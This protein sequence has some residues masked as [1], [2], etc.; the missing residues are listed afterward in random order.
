[1]IHLFIGT[2]AQFIKMAP[3]MAEMDR[4][5]LEYNYIDSG[6]HEAFTQSLRE[7]FGIRAPN[8][9]LGKGGLDI[10]TMRSAAVWALRLW[11]G[12][13]F[14]KKWLREEVF[15]SGGICLAHGDTLS[16]LLGLRM[17]KTAGCVVG[18]VEAGLRSRSFFHPFPE[19]IIRMYCMRR[20]ELLFAPSD[21]A[22]RNLIDMRVSGE[23]VHVGGN[24][25]VDALRLVEKIDPSINIPSVP[26]ALAACHR[27]E[28]ITNKKRLGAVVNLLNRVSREMRVLFVTH[29]P[30][31]KRLERY[32]ITLKLS[33]KV[34]LLEMQDYASF[35]GLMRNAKLVFADGGSIQEECAYLNK[36]CLIL[37]KKTERTDGLGKNAMLWGF[38][39]QVLEVFLA[40]AKYAPPVVD[41]WP[42]PSKRIV[43]YLAAHYY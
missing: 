3:V 4:R 34:E 7:T 27:F 26:Y 5:G 17:A 14:R 24:T 8:V 31:R 25:V 15:P 11:G 33:K 37:R 41:N 32:G 30:T 21:E 20:C 40:K 29:K 38:D 39:A 16:T 12:S 28:T 1:M 22:V 6:Q 9:C 19:E 13:I 35:T 36:P 23:V 18:H 42:E 10:T 43:D 2:K